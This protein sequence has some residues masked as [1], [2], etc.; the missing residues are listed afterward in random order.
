V[1]E[2]NLHLNYDLHQSWVNR[3]CRKRIHMG[4]EDAST[5]EAMASCKVPVLL[6]HGSDDSF[7]PVEM[8]YENYKACAAPKKLLIVPGATHGLSYLTEPARYQ[9]TVRELWQENDPA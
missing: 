6:V 4:A 1:A 7:V 3:L 2:R 8:T 5:L 9:E